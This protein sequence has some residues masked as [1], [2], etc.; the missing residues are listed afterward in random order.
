MIF[1]RSRSIVRPR[2]KTSPIVVYMDPSSTI[3]I[4][5]HL[6]YERFYGLLKDKYISVIGAL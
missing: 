2:L 5:Y 3:T 4:K 1:L 6:K